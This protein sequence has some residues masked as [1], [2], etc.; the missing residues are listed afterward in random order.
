MDIEVQWVTLTGTSGTA[1]NPNRHTWCEYQVGVHGDRRG[2]RQEVIDGL[3]NGHDMFVAF[4]SKKPQE[5]MFTHGHS[6]SVYTSV[7]WCFCNV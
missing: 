5:A 7:C 1:G 3:D 6:L 2:H 4:F